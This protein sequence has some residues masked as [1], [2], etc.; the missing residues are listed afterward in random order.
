ML[1]DA[2]K[3]EAVHLRH[4]D[5]RKHRVNARVLVQCI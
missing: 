5:V 3:I 1:D 4:P 2:Q